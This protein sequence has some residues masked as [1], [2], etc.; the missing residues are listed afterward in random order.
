MHVKDTSQTYHKLLILQNHTKSISYRYANSIKNACF[1][2]LCT[3]MSLQQPI[4]EGCSPHTYLEL[5]QPLSSFPQNP[6]YL[7]LRSSQKARFLSWWFQVISRNVSDASLRPWMIGILCV[8]CV[9]FFVNLKPT[10]KKKT[11]PNE[12][13]ICSHLDAS[14][15]PGRSLIGMQHLFG[16]FFAL[17]ASTILYPFSGQGGW[18]PISSRSH[19]AGNQLPTPMW[20][21]ALEDDF[22]TCHGWD[23]ACSSKLCFFEGAIRQI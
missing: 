15:H 18:E 3:N 20:L 6:W 12:S 22:L 2:H 16:E 10:P 5:L 1:V 19:F 14:F 8:K 9:P 23:T 7:G 11:K 4:L 13:Y 17:E 21:K